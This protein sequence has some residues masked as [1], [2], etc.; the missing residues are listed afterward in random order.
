LGFHYSLKFGCNSL[1]N[2]I[3]VIRQKW[4]PAPQ[5]SIISGTG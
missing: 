3:K 2:S 1:I 5:N 4:P